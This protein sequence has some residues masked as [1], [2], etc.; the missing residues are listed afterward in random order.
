MA[1]VLQPPRNGDGN[2]Q[3][4]IL[5]TNLIFT[6]LAS[7]IVA[8]RL[9]TRVFLVRNVGLD[10]Y[11]IILATFGIIIGCALVIVQVHY[12]FGR[13]RFYLTEWQYIER[14]KY[15]YG[16]WIQTF[17]T[18][19]FTKLSI[20][21]FLLRIPVEK[22]FIRPIQGAIVFLVVTNIVLTL[23]WIF[24]CNPIDGAWNGNSPSKCF[25]EAQLQRII[26][27]QAI[28]SAL[29]DFALALFPIALL[30]KV[31]INALMN[32]QNV[33]S[34]PTWA[35]IVNWAWRT[36]EVCIGIIAASIP[37]LR[38]GYRLL[39]TSLRTY[40]SHR[41]SSAFG[42]IKEDGNPHF[43]KEPVAELSAAPSAE[44][45]CAMDVGE[46]EVGFAMNALPGDKSIK[47]TTRID[48]DIGSQRS[49]GLHGD[50]RGEE[51][52]RSFV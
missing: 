45:D 1:S 43:G 4:G 14:A 31:Q 36:A 27:S 42:R 5:A 11:T 41:S 29:S 20:C 17:Q 46:G 12:G 18:L 28:I 48:V 49:L 23:L 50:G 34:D 24:Q 19:M 30:W 38:P 6:I 13:H 52:R 33:N 21:F 35:S 3:G 47:K 10:D 8:L 7:I 40:L 26:I 9:A 15:S 16:E 51:G 39:S 32:W 2:R 44:I 37:A 22:I 25:T